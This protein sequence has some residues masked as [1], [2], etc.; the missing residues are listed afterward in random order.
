MRN[1]IV[2]R[3]IR[4]FLQEVANRLFL[5]ELLTKIYFTGSVRN[6]FSKNVDVKCSKKTRKAAIV[7]GCFR[8]EID[9]QKYVT[10][11]SCFVLPQ[12]S[13]Y[14]HFPMSGIFA[15]RLGSNT[16]HKHQTSKTPARQDTTSNLYTR[17]GVSNIRWG[18]KQK[19]KEEKNNK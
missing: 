17:G 18:Y 2:R 4:L 1:K 3:K 19:K 8:H 13:A 14:Q 12:M 11:L 5:M 16:A 10:S 7:T 15:E 9:C 6:S